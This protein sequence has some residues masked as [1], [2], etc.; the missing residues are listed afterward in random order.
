MRA[1]RAATAIASPVVLLLPIDEELSILCLFFV[2]LKIM[3][4]VFVV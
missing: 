3:F 1:R 4:V 2:F